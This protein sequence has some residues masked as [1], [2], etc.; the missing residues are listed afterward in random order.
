[1]K[2]IKSII[3]DLMII[4]GSGGISYGAYLINEPYGYISAGII[5]VIVGVLMAR[6]AA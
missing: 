3:P 4:S 1:M 2:F 6:S 5:G